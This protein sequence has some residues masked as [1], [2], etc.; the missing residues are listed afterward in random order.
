MRRLHPVSLAAL[1]L[2][3]PAW[4]GT[5]LAQ[6]A[7]AIAQADA[8]PVDQSPGE[9]EIVVT[10]TRL[11][12]QVQTDSPPILELDEQQVAAYGAASI[13]D[14]VA[15]LAPQTGSGRGRGGRPVFLVNGQRVSGFREFSRFPPEAIRKVEVL[16]EEV[17]LQFGYPPDA[18]VINFILKDNFASRTIEAEYGMPTRGGTSTAQGEASLLTINGPRRINGS[19]EYT[20]TSP[21]TEAERGVIQ[22]PG[23]DPT[24]PGD[25]DPADYRTLV[26]RDEK[27]EANAT[28]T[29]GLGEM[30]SGKQFTLNGNVTRDV[31]TSLSGLDTVLLTSPS[32]DQ[33]L[34]T[35]D[36]DPISRR[37]TTDTYSLGSTFNAPLGDW[38]YSGTLDAS[39][40][41]S[42]SRRDRRRD[43][44]A[45]AAAAAAGTLAIDAPLPSVADAGF[46]RTLSRVWSA[47][48]KNTLAGSPL[49]LPGGEVNV[50]LDAG[51][52]WTRIESRDSRAALGETQL[53]RGDLNA[54]VNLNLPI[55]SMREGFLDAIGDLSL[56]L[57][58][59]IDHLSDFGTLTDWNVGTT[60][61]PAERLALKA[62]Y[63]QR[64]VAPGL[65]QLG[66]PVIL[67][68]NVPVYDFT[69]GRTVLAN[70]TSGGNP[71]LLAETQRDFKLSANYDLDWFD[72]TNL[73][74]EYFSNR[75]SNTT[76]AFPL[77]TPAI[78]AAFPDRVTR[79]S[80]GTLLAIDRRPVTFAERSSSRIRYGINMSGKLGKPSPEGEGQGRGGRFGAMMG[81]AAPSQPAPA[82]GTGGGFDPARFGEMR[83]RFCAAPEGQAPDLSGLPE[84]MLER[85][86]GEDGQIDPA[87]VAALKARFCAADGGGMRTFDPARFA[88]LRT[89]LACGVEGSNAD[90]ATLPAE[91]ADRLKGPDGTIDPARLAEFRSRICAL[92]ADGSGGTGGRGGWRGRGGQGSPS[93]EQAAGG[94]RQSG[95]GGGFGGRRGGDGQGRWNLSLYHTIEL[96]NRALIADGGPE[97]DLLAGDG[98]SDG[99]VSRHKVEL[100]GGV[101]RKGLGARLSGNYLSGTTVRGSGLPGSSDLKF[102]DLATFD[103][104]LF[105]NLEQ[106]K[107]LTG[108][109]EPGF[110]K[111]ARLSF[112]I[113]N[114]FDAHQRVT[115]VNGLVPLRYQP[116]LI[117]PVGR[118]FEIEFR[119]MF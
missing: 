105:A 36:A 82:S 97:L 21:L 3:A 40:T 112:R 63:I 102:G 70:V 52:D 46:D 53:T 61:K 65:S 115:D 2:T 38:R 35:L 29:T 43:T 68:V 48:Q 62:S 42:D 80:D 94:G 103:L 41:D 69:T 72:R 24:V 11:P 30:G 54:G 110:W 76:E 37:T 73:V 1:A 101:F 118:R 17:A 25:A 44:A 50:T 26:A 5:A 86:K 13:A 99:G 111:G 87:K 58:A 116:G 96:R 39:R 7:P 27:V 78:E 31:R 56:N 91:I 18:R 6:D 106:Q 12:G 47:S 19:V 45:L 67:D 109:G 23:T 74:V 88:A 117:D 95:G 51:Y 64:E 114:L 92:P 71:D 119:K 16:P 85:L 14:L 108:G 113:D 93:G 10:A 107:W 20:R 77:L 104:R 15:Q 84:R 49:I 4:T 32:G 57:G 89:A 81:I 34:R 79:A 59:G 28:F 60:W 66:G 8:P 100:E 83:T 9:G 33:A 98:L 22:T 75:S 55:A 90:P